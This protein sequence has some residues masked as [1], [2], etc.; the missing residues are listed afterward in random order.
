MH[1]SV[2]QALLWSQLTRESTSQ[3]FWKRLYM[4]AQVQEPAQHRGKHLSQSI[5]TMGLSEPLVNCLEMSRF[6]DA[7]QSEQVLVETKGGCHRQANGEGLKDTRE[8]GT[9]QQSFR[10]GWHF[11]SEF[12]VK[13]MSKKN[14]K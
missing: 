7:E 8:P 6:G 13:K 4:K 12:L 2:L 10:L 5:S 3:P 9:R 11:L 1:G 14:Q